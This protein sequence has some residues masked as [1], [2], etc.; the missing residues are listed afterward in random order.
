MVTLKYLT[1]FS[2]ILE[3]PLINW[4]V[5]LQLKWPIKRFLVVG[6]IPNQ[7]ATFTIADTKRYVL[8]VTLSTQE[9]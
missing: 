5:N 7:V 9:S 4:A 3:M 8:V 1:N 6:T 2:W